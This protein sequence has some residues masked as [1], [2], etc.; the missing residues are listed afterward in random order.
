MVPWVAI[1]QRL[2]VGAQGAGQPEQPVPGPR[3]E[4]TPRPVDV[5]DAVAG[6]TIVGEDGVV[7]L[8][9]AHR[10]DRVAPEFG[11]PHRLLTLWLL[12]GDGLVGFAWWAWAVD[13][14]FGASDGHVVDA[15]LA[16]AHVAVGV[17]LPVLV[18][19]AAPALP[20]VVV[21]DRALMTSSSR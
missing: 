17:E 2:T 14:S 6:D 7:E 19:V 20:G 9:T 13:A 16:T 1:D 11:D 21:W 10:L 18:A 4:N 3:G 12:E 5:G 8:L 15:G